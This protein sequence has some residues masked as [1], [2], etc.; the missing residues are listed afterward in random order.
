MKDLLAL[1]ISGSGSAHRSTPTAGMETFRALTG[2][3]ARLHGFR[4]FAGTS[5]SDPR[6]GSRPVSH[7]DQPWA[8]EI[9]G[10]ASAPR[11]R[12]PLRAPYIPHSYL[13]GACPSNFPSRCSSRA[14]GRTCRRCSTRV[15][16]REARIV[17]VAS[18]TPDAPALDRARERGVAT[19]VFAAIRLRRPRGPGRGPGASGCS[20]GAPAWSCWPAT[21]SSWGP[22]SWIASPARSSTSTRPC[23]RPSRG[24]TRSSRRSPTASRCSA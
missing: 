12:S 8:A 5:F 17:A 24:C 2:R 18:S 1:G 10:W 14:R 21:W 22:P 13:P 16:E 23:C 7:P 15:H 11:R 19:E 3:T 9:S 6:A 20:S 4:H